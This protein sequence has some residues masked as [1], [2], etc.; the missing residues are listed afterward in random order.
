MGNEIKLEL[1]EFEGL[2]GLGQVRK[3]VELPGWKIELHT[4]SSLEYNEMNGRLPADSASLPDGQRFE[5]IQ[6]EILTSAVDKI[7]DKAV[8]FETKKAIFSGAQLALCNLLYGEYS[9]MLDGQN[10]QLQIV[11]KNS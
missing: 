4:L 2:M 6:R 9:N 3:V 5:L 11:K 8:S 1:A 7:N 10:A